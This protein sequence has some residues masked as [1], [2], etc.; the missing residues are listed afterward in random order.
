MQL[1]VRL[2]G[3]DCSLNSTCAKGML[4]PHP[5]RVFFDLNW[6]AF[7]AIWHQAHLESFSAYEK[8]GRT[9]WCAYLLKI[10]RH[11]KRQRCFYLQPERFVS[12]HTWMHPATATQVYFGSSDR[13][14]D[15]AEFV[16]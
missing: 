12:F 13:F 4:V 14:A 9:K 1:M 2:H 5:V 7:D 3:S 11:L 8:Q 15:L 6:T 16:K 10:K